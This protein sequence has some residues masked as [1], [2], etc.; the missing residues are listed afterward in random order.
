M[1]AVV[2]FA[3]ALCLAR[4]SLLRAAD[5]PAESKSD[6]VAVRGRVVCL[7]ALSATPA[8]PEADPCNQPGARFDLRVSPTEVVH[9]LAE[10]PKAEIFTDPQVRARDIE[11]HGWR[12]PGDGFEILSVYSIRGGV[13]HHLHY[14][15]DVCNITA[16]APGPCWCCGAPFELREEPADDAVSHPD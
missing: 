1:A 4:A 2:A 5:P 9:F 8:N 11:V 7:D 16:S 10:D 3:S 15:C 6:V 14:R 12:R 13:P